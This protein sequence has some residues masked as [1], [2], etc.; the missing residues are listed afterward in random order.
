MRKTMPRP[1]IELDKKKFETLCRQHM[2][3][4]K[5]ALAFGVDDRTVEAW[6]RRTYK[7]SFCTISEQK[8]SEGEAMLI[9]NAFKLAEKAPAVMIFLL[10]NWC[11][12]RDTPDTDD[13]SNGV[14]ADMEK[15]FNNVKGNAD[16]GTDTEA[17]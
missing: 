3:K 11:G 6:C 14:T 1:R 10:K 15:W 5:I 7:C 16:D 17:T 13:K 12:M 4:A 8:K 2:S 9:N